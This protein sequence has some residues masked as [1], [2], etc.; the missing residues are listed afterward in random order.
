MNN[1]GSSTNAERDDAEATPAHWAPY[2]DSER[3]DN[4]RK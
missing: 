4:Y 3:D 1:A 2:A